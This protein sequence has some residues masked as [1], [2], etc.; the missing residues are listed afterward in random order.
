MKQNRVVLLGLWLLCLLL[1]SIAF[2]DV[3]SEARRHF[4]TGMDLIAQG[5]LDEGAVELEAAY[6]LMPHPNVLYNLARAYFD[7][8]QYVETVLY[9]ERYLKSDPA[10]S[11]QV[12]LIVD[13]LKDRL[14]KQTLTESSPSEDSFQGV[15]GSTT[16]VTNEVIK[17]IREA[18]KRFAGIA[19]A[20]QSPSLKNQ[21][22]ILDELARTLVTPSSQTKP[23]EVVQGT[24]S[25]ATAGQPK[26]LQAQLK[27]G[28]V[29]DLDLG[30]QRT[31]DIYAERVVSASRLAQSPLDAPNST[32]V[33]TAQDIRLSGITNIGELLRRAAGIEV[34]TL[35]PADT[36]IS[37]RGLNQRLSNKVLVLIDGRSVFLDFLGATLWTILPIGVEDIE[38]IEVIRGPASAL[39]GADAF[40][41]VINILL[42]KPG[43]GDTLVTTTIGEG[44]S[45]RASA[46]FTGRSDQVGYRFNAGHIQS[47]QYS[48]GIDPARVDIEST[49][50]DP[51]VGIGAKWFNSEFN[52][53]LPEKYTAQ[54]GTAVLNGDF[55][56]MSAG[57][58]RNLQAQ[59]AFF[60]QS[61]A[62]LST[63]MGITLRSF[64]TAF[65]T[66]VKNLEGRP[67]D[68]DV[69]FDDLES[70]VVDI[71]A[72]YDATFEWP[73]AHHLNIGVG[74]RYKSIDWDWLDAKHDE[75]HASAFIQDTMKFGEYVRVTASTRI[76][77]HPLISAP[78]LSPR[79][80]V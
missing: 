65:T 30:S 69:A 15:D 54:V 9:F 72:E 33:V 57:R 76:D 53:R 1:P 61:H 66:D 23:G 25:T 50:K 60:A 16:V 11:D 70:H 40:S 22:D 51:A 78:V 32:T 31:E 26:K 42:K 8:G 20:T 73:I 13:A 44:T 75:H 64:W 80:A 74:Y 55:S 46:R 63:P 41:G 28:A 7:A 47:N 59:D 2:A 45:I 34:M 77:K 14:A 5:Q 56:F 4:R 24:E 3:R 37:I 12:Q 29:E 79:G 48:Y 62:N 21:A 67:D 36:E 35:T 17:V 27:P 6:A 39:Y 49:V 71:E 38:R 10:D 52:I 19:A 68:V 43:Q 58:L 18:S